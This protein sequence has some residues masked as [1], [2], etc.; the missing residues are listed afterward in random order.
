[1]DLSYLGTIVN[2][3]QP[4]MT[5]VLPLAWTSLILWRFLSLVNK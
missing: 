3:L 4:I 2:H 1:M 5:R